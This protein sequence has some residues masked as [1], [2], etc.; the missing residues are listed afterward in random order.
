MENFENFWS[1]WQESESHGKQAFHVQKGSLTYEL[2]LVLYRLA[3]KMIK[4]SIFEQH[5]ATGNKTH[6]ITFMEKY[7][8]YDRK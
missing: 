2:V 3:D 1:V 6:L 8:F 4:T 7:P 5:V